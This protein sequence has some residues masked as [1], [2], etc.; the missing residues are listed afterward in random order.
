[1]FKACDHWWSD[2]I[3]RQWVPCIDKYDSQK[4]WP[5]LTE[6]IVFLSFIL[7][8]LVYLLERW[9]IRLG[10]LQTCWQGGINVSWQGV[11]C[12]DNVHV[13]LVVGSP[14]WWGLLCTCT[15]CTLDNPALLVDHF[16]AH[17]QVGLYVYSTNC[18]S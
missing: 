17:S 11:H 7:L 14:M 9:K 13:C 5:L 3:I 6:N 18:L 10:S 8:P 4:M 12:F 1:M 15:L 2:N 16:I